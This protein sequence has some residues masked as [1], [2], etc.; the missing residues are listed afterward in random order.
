MPSVSLG[1]FFVILSLARQS[2]SSAASPVLPNDKII[3]KIRMALRAMRFAAVNCP[4]SS[5]LVGTANIF[6]VG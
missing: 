4:F 3:S 1:A 6:N 2:T 5:G